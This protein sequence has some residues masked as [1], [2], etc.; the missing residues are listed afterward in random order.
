MI[1]SE[2]RGFFMKFIF[3]L[4]IIYVNFVYAKECG[5]DWSC[6][7]IEQER[8]LKFKEEEQRQ[9]YLEIQEKQI[10]F[11][12]EE[13]NELQIQN[14]ILEAQEVRLKEIHQKLL[15][16]SSEMKKVPPKEEESE[17]EIGSEVE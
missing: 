11:Q 6:F 2:K 12:Q 13:V 14:S 1:E 4:I 7:Y 3:L 5:S 10:Q 15:D 8:I 16:I 17:E 9:E